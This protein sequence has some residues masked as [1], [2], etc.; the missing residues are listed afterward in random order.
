MA[1]EYLIRIV[2]KLDTQHADGGHSVC[3]LCCEFRQ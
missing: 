2:E 3:R 1:T